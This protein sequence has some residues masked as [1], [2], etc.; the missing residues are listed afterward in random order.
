MKQKIILFHFNEKNFSLKEKEIKELKKNYFKIILYNNHHHAKFNYNEY[1]SKKLNKIKDDYK[2]IKINLNLKKIYEINHFLKDIK[3]KNKNKKI[4]ISP[5]FISN[6]ILEEE[7]IFYELSKVYKMQF[8]RPE[9][10]FIKNRYLLAKN[11]FK[12]HYTLKRKTIFSKKEFDTLKINYIASME[13]FNKNEINPKNLNS[14]IYRTL[15]NFLNFLLNSRFNKNSKKYALI[16]L[17]NNKNLNS[18][19]KSMNLQRYVQRFLNKFN[20]ELVFLFHPRTNVIKYL[21]KEIKNKNFFF[22]R[23]QTSFLQNPINLINIVRNSE[24]IIHQSSSLSAQTLF[25]NKKILI[26]GKNEIYIKNINNIVL[27]IR[28]NNFNFLKKNIKKNDILKIDKYLISLLSNSVNY[29]GEFNLYT[30]KLFYIF[31][32]KRNEKKIIQNLLNGI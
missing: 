15:I 3:L 27:N 19:S 25:L 8:V 23:N 6:T 17:N 4:Y 13:T 32:E 11:I 26:L 10:S 9:L 21:F 20:Y 24:F 14:Y 22:K 29:K 30:K 16:V 2:E 18:L 31:N 12:H 5:Y 7:F 28:Q 1:N